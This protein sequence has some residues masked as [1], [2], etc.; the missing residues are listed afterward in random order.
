MLLL[1]MHEVTQ[2]ITTGV[3]PLRDPQRTHGINPHTILTADSACPLLLGFLGED[4]LCLMF[5]SFVNS[6][7]R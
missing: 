5:Q 3:I 1:Q 6:A 4:V 2:E 7:K